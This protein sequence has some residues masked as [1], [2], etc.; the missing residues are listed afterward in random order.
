MNELSPELNKITEDHAT[1]T[2]VRVGLKSG[3]WFTGILW[4]NERLKDGNRSENG[5]FLRVQEESIYPNLD[6]DMYEFH[7]VVFIKTESV[8]YIRYC[9]E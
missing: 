9:R 2:L 3:T 7:N 5:F 1:G 6:D 4:S 8:E